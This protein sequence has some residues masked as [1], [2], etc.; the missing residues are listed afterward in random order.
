MDTKVKLLSQK[1]IDLFLENDPLEASIHSVS[2][3]A[4]II[5][6]V[7]SS[8]DFS[9]I[10]VVEIFDHREKR[11]VLVVKAYSQ[12]MEPFIPP[13]ISTYLKQNKPHQFK[14]KTKVE[15]VPKFIS[16]YLKQLKNEFKTQ[17]HEIRLCCGMGQENENSIKCIQKSIPESKIE[18]VG[19]L[20]RL[21][22]NASMENLFVSFRTKRLFCVYQN[23]KEKLTKCLASLFLET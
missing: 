15:M 13:F 18:H 11:C 1:E 2:S 16:I 4:T 10:S 14:H 6:V 5:T 8:S 7:N 12:T 21:N 17:S 19:L 20:G 22:R 9:M 23:T 3:D